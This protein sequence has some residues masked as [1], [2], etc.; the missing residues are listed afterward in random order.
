MAVG[1]T[2]VVINYLIFLPAIYYN[3]HY[4]LAGFLAFAGALQWNFFWNRTITFDKPKKSFWH[5]YKYFSLVNLG[6]LT[7]HQFLLLILIGRFQIWEPLA[8]I[9]AIFGGFMINYFGS[10]KIAFK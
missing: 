8:N 2:V 1:G 3:L 10:E 5:Q 6:G 4:M 7:V 9:I